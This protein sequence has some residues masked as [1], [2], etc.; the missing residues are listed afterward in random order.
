[1]TDTLHYRRNWFAPL[2]ASLILLIPCCWLVVKWNAVRI[3]RE[4]A[5]AIE[6]GGGRVEYHDP[7]G[8]AWLRKFLG[9]GY[10]RHARIV[11]FGPETSDADLERVVALPGLDS[12]VLDGTNVT[13]AG[14]EHLERLKQLRCL[15]VSRTNITDA[16]LRHLKRL[17]IE[18][19]CLGGT[20]ITDVGLKE[21]TGASGCYVLHLEFTQVTDAGLQ[22][23]ATLPNLVRVSLDGTKVT[24][25]GAKRLQSALPDCKIER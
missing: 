24:D 3:E 14:L 5:A 1:M 10:F 18:K 20:Q 8:P 6:K 19:L 23:L 16:G 17:Q 25:A 22:S 21:L 15:A 13:D 7:H 4:V 11:Y 12:L 9:D 2:A